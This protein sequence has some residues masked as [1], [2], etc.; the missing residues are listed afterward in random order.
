[1]PGASLNSGTAAAQEPF[2]ERFPQTPQLVMLLI[3]AVPF[4]HLVCSIVLPLVLLSSFTARLGTFA[5]L[6]FLV[7]PL[8]ARI[9][10]RLCPLPE[11]DISTATRGF[12]VW[13]FVFQLQM[14]FCRLPFLEELMRLV[15]GLYSAWLRA[16][17]SRIGRCVY[18]G[19]GTT[20]LER[21]LLDIGDLVVLGAGVR[22]NGHVL[23][24]SSLSAVGDTNSGLRLILGR[25]K[26][27]DRALVG[28]YSL[29]T[30]GSSIPEAAVTPPCALFSPF[31][32]YERSKRRGQIIL[33]LQGG[34]L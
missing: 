25:I 15:P 12:L 7:P 31:S 33:P 24:Q 3:N 1:M 18:W 30:A 6:F 34:A 28:G 23:G 27:G 19:A 10:M 2:D 22:L 26:I 5:A 13:W 29:I 11:G 14:V 32:S 4:V 21:S 9:V 17:G 20:V 16:W 8:L